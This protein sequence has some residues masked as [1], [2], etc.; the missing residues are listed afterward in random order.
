MSTEN[1]DTRAV[2]VVTLTD[3]QVDLIKL[4]L[5][6]VA[7]TIGA[8]FQNNTYYTYDPS[9]F[10]CT[11]NARITYQKFTV[12]EH[13]LDD[14]VFSEVKSALEKRGVTYLSLIVRP[15]AMNVETR[16]TIGIGNVKR[17]GKSAAGGPYR[18][19]VF[20]T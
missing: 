4:A 14:I 11:F 13:R 19:T 16:T 5:L 10:G 8:G 18:S 17:D 7:K 3:A 2:N 9:C 1:T 15:Q 20:G 6:D 12:A